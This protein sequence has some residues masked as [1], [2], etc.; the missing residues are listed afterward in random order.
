[1]FSFY[2]LLIWSL[3]CDVF[4]FLIFCYIKSSYV[5]QEEGFWKKNTLNVPNSVIPLIPEC[6]L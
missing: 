1:M 4:F 5:Q 6:N 3:L 2:L